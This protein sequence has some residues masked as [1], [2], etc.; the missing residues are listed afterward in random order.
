MDTPSTRPTVRFG[1]GLA[2]VTVLAA[3]MIGPPWGLV[4]LVGWPLPERIPTG[5]DLLAW[6]ETAMS[7]AVIID[8]L[9][10]ACWIAWAVFVLDV[11]A[12]FIERASGRSLIP[13][14][15]GPQRALAV[16]LVTGIAFALLGHRLTGTSPAPGVAA[17]HQYQAITRTLVAHDLEPHSNT[18][19]VRPPHSGTHDSLSLI[20]EEHLG[21]GNQW[22]AIYDLNRGAAQTDGRSLDDPDL[23]HPGWVLQLPT[24]AASRVIDP[25]SRTEPAPANAHPSGGG[26][27]IQDENVSPDTGGVELRSGA[28]VGTGLIAAIAAAVAAAMLWRRRRYRPGSGDRSDL[29]FEPVI[30][31]MRTTA[32]DLASPGNEHETE[33]HPGLPIGTR[34]GEVL[35]PDA[36]THSGIGLVG[37][38]APSA[39]RALLI[40]WLTQMSTDGGQ[41]KIMIPT[42]DI[43]T[44]LG[45]GVPDLQPF[46]VQV[47]PDLHHALDALQVELVRRTRIIEGDLSSKSEFPSLMLLASVAAADAGR[48]RTIV[49]QGATLGI[50]AVLLGSFDPARTVRVRADGTIGAAGADYE[51]QLGG[52]RMFNLPAPDAS[53]ILRVLAEAAGFQNRPTAPTIEGV[54]GDSLADLEIITGAPNPTIPG[55]GQGYPPGHDAAP[56]GQGQPAAPRAGASMLA[57]DH[58]E[59]QEDPSSV[60]TTAPGDIDTANGPT[61]PP[62]RRFSMQLLGEPLLA[63][64]GDTD[65]LQP[66]PQQ[67]SQ[68]QWEI[69]VQLALH[70]DGASRDTIAAAI[71]PDVDS[72]NTFHATMSHIRKLLR[73]VGVHGDTII[74]ENGRRYRLDPDI[75]DVDLWRL[76]DALTARKSDLPDGTRQSSTLAV[77]RLY[78]GDLA[79]DISGVW[80]HSEREALRRTVLDVISDAARRLVKA[81]P[82]AILTLLEEARRIDP[83][84]QA[85]YRD[86]A[87]TQAELGQYSAISRTL[88]LLTIKLKERD[89]K[90]CKLTMD[91]FAGLQQ[92]EYQNLAK[93]GQPTHLHQRQ[94]PRAASGSTP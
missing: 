10:C 50:T 79:A 35:R 43:E 57:A 42:A 15:P 82:A 5:A 31:A 74:Q 21:N 92:R 18:V 34:D 59:Q 46:P 64:R 3:L 77:T 76:D 65:Q 44:L 72:T 66:T 86:I 75:V 24:A 55:N 16:A 9:A 47:H 26:D 19:T 23:I 70:R 90:P 13:A 73:G 2:A 78:R 80:L 69:L 89:A 6:L 8:I 33:P 40:T 88:S 49:D 68:K 48:V 83:Y 11:V 22:P 12:A 71:W 87:R 36:P 53:A 17:A 84:N 32:T 54:E 41:V 58:P 7:D 60:E 25:P 61:T 4:R 85:I 81:G 63:I 56:P 30:E 38:G 51:H 20:A 39:A 45:G 93:N 14:P 37:P 1:T 29:T 67:P 91:V 27:E 52:C 94:T 28:Y 62:V